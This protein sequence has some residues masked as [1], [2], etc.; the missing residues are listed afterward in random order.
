MHACKK[1]KADFVV[2]LL[3]GGADFADLDVV[4]HSILYKWMTSISW[5][6]FVI[7]KT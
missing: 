7:Y 3:E 6:E 1:K 2:K 4:S 5:L